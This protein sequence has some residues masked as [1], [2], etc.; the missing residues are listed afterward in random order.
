MCRC[1]R[2]NIK[3]A[4]PKTPAE[5]HVDYEIEA[6]YVKVSQ[7]YTCQSRMLQHLLRQ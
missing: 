2:S 3:L 5:Q 4:G 7:C 6:G 1:E